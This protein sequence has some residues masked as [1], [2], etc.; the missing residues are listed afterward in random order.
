M[1]K[2]KNKTKTGVA[3]MLELAG[4]KKSRLLAACALSVVASAARI[5]PFFMIYGMMRELLRCYAEPTQMDAT[6]LSIFAGLTLAAA[7][8]YG[9][10]AFLSSSLAH[11]A[12]YDIIYA[13]RLQLL[14][15]LARVPSGYFTQTTQGAIKKILSDDTEQLEVFIAHHICDIVAAVATPLLTLIYL[16]IMDWRLALVTLVPIIISLALLSTCLNKPEKAALQVELHDSQER[17]QGTIVEYIHGMPVIKVFNRT[18]GAFRRYERDLNGFVD[19]VTRTAYA[20]AKPMGAYYAFFGAQLLFLLPASLLLL[21]QAESYLDALPLVLLFF[22][23]GS[24]LKEPLEDMMVKVIDT[25]RISEGMRRIDEILQLEEV[26]PGGTGA[27]THYDVQFENVTFAYGDGAVAVDGVSFALAAGSVTGLVGPSGGGKSTLAQLLLRFYAPQQGT[28]RIGGV[29]IATIP[30]ERLTELVSYVFQESVLFHDTVENNIR[31]GDTAASREDVVRAAKNA[32]IH[33]VIQRLPQGYD[34]VIGEG[35]AFLS[36]GEKQRLAIAR[37]FL[38]D[39]PIV[40]LDEATAYAD[41][42]NEARIQKAFARLAKD[43]TVLII[44]HRLKT[45]EKADQ[46]L[47]MEEGRLLGAGT[48]DAL[49]ATC[50][51]YAE[52]VAANERRE[53]WMIRSMRREVQA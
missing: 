31:M 34:T 2:Q 44:A 21:S 26:S 22:I 25:N 17:M 11:T 12:A 16:F 27:P 10:C 4:R 15:K 6:R 37:V 14:E 19:A 32:E 49:M 8:V 47:V 51:L 42:E 18:L 46:I 29:D 53:R 13:L 41:A 1:K 40:L 39:T 38:R 35:A 30:P 20:N 50:S 9:L 45:V 7:L 52:M 36:G 48:H 24:G 5:V 28:I 43:K 3:R 33:D 23:V